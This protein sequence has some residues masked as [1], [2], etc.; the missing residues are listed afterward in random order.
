MSIDCIVWSGKC[1]IPMNHLRL[2]ISSKTLRQSS[3]FRA[4][5]PWSVWLPKSKYEFWR[6]WHQ[7]FCGLVLF[8]A[9]IEKSIKN[10]V[11]KLKKSYVVPK[12]GRPFKTPVTSESCSSRGRSVA[13]CLSGHLTSSASFSASHWMSLPT[14]AT[15]KS[16]PSLFSKQSTSRDVQS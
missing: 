14:Y 6:V 8:W 10:L 16:A 13:T 1:K 9:A 2:S 7:L 5:P 12:K 11:S 15:C 3:S 4:L